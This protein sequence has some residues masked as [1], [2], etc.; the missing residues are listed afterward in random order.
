MLIED[1]GCFVELV[2]GRGNRKAHEWILKNK[3]Y[4]QYD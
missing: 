4:E 3:C 1:G 2:C